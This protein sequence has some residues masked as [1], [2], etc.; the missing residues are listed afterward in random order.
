MQPTNLRGKPPTHT[1]TNIQQH[2][3]WTLTSVKRQRCYKQLHP[4][5]PANT[6]S[7][8]KQKGCT[9]CQLLRKERMQGMRNYKMA[10]V[11]SLD[12]CIYLCPSLNVVSIISSMEVERAKPQ[13]AALLL[14]LFQGLRLGYCVYVCTR[15][16]ACTHVH[17]LEINNW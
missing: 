9:H 3:M 6:G 7:L 17:D 15:I 5:I 1:H 4:L 10:E 11:L 14:P 8:Q 16:L 13:S 2:C 12:P